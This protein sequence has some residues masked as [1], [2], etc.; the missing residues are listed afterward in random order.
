[1]SLTL[2][3]ETSVLDQLTAAIERSLTARRMAAPMVFEQNDCVVIEMPAPR[4]PIDELD[5]RL[6]GEYTLVIGSAAQ[7]FQARVALPAR[8]S[9]AD[10]VVYCLGG[11]LS[12]TFL[13]ADVA[14]EME[15]E[16]DPA[17]DLALA[18]C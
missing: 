12:M 17:L 18:A 9:V 11:I 3:P 7:G 5:M 4:T 13:K 8:I 10:S 15:C 1:M 16:D 14:D 6:D 2:S